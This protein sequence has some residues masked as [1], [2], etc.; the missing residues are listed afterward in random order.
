MGTKESLLAAGGTS[1]KWQLRDRLGK[2]VEMGA[3]VKWL[4]NG[5][6]RTGVVVDS[7]REGYATVEEDKTKRRLDMAS[8]RLTVIDA[9]TGKRPEEKVVAPEVSVVPEA[10]APTVPKADKVSRTA[11]GT[12]DPTPLAPTPET[13]ATGSRTVPTAKN[14]KDQ[15]LFNKVWNIIK[16]FRQPDGSRRPGRPEGDGSPEDPIYV[17]NDVNKA[18]EL[19]LE[20]KHIRMSTED[21]VATVVAKLGP[22][23][24]KKRDGIFAKYNLAPGTKASD[25]SDGEA[26]DAMNSLAI[27]LCVVHVPG[28]NLF[29]EDNKGI[30]RVHMPQLSGKDKD[31]KRRNVQAQAMEM[32]ESMN[33]IA[34]EPVLV[35]P[36][37]VRASQSELGAEQIDGMVKNYM[38]WL[39]MQEKIKALSEGD[40]KR[41]ELEAEVAAGEHNKYMPEEV[42]TN[43]IL[44]TK[45]KYI[46]DGHHRWAAMILANIEREAKGLPPLQMKIREVDMEVGE[47]LATVNAF[48]DAAGIVRAA[49]AGAEGKAVGE[50]PKILQDSKVRD[51]ILTW[52][53]RS[54]RPVT[55]GAVEVGDMVVLDGEIREVLAIVAQTSA[56]RTF[57]T[58]GDSGRS[59]TVLHPDSR[60]VRTNPL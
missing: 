37:D 31:G 25:L 48:A 54:L 24:K 14:P 9:K 28:T 60:L 42:L 58:Q 15:T 18:V 40:P 4:A 47:A 3:A 23:I 55:A 27:N 8:N 20:G 30:P 32:L 45:D 53:Q 41:A 56:G 22:E 34:P 44:T 10:P 21:I 57:L 50:V 1:W 5:L 16:P 19:I 29:C 46:I 2:W 43:T 6:A 17:G 38:N 51:A 36:E 7:P 33:L 59:L 12:V 49:A 52:I 11:K 35:N 39:D 26:K 13:P